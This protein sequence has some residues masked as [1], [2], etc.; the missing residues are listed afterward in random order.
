MSGLLFILKAC[1]YVE[2]LLGDFCDVSAVW[3]SLRIM[4]STPP[5]GASIM[6]YFSVVA[7]VCSVLQD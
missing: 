1:R 6:A 4:V 7:L 3:M 2:I 5:H